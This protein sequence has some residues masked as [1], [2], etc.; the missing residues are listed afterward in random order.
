M[1]TWK[2]R[3]CCLQS[4][5]ALVRYS[6]LSNAE[7]LQRVIHV[8]QKEDVGAFALNPHASIGKSDI[9]THAKGS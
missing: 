3:H 9:H 1:R 2:S 7:V 8:C 5:C 4:R 6:R